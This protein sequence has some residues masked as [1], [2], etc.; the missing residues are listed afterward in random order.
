MNSYF[1]RLRQETAA[2]VPGST[3][4]AARAAY[5]AT[6]TR[7]AAVWAEL[8]S[9]TA[10][11]PHTRA[12]LLGDLAALEEQL[13]GHYR[14]GWNTTRLDREIAGGHTVSAGVLHLVAS[15]ETAESLQDR[16]DGSLVWEEAFGYVLDALVGEAD[17]GRRAELMTRL[18][19][20]AYPV[21]GDD[22]GV[23]DRVG[24]AYVRVAV[25]QHDYLTEAAV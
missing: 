17:L 15:T 23:I 10:R 7:A 11:H 8:G 20:A 9:R 25:A 21:I 3:T 4:R 19:L 16:T 14:A 12:L 24:A 1:A 5:V 6:A 18:Y 22:A 2:L 13:A